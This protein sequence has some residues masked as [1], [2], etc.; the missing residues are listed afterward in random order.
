M[1]TFDLLA[2][3]GKHTKVFES[4]VNALLPQR[5][6][7]EISELLQ[8]SQWKI[9]KI[10]SGLHLET[11]QAR[12][13]QNIQSLQDMVLNTH[14]Y[15]DKENSHYNII[16]DEVSNLTLAVIESPNKE[17]LNQWYQELDR[18]TKGKIKG[19]SQSMNPHIKSIWKNISIIISKEIPKETREE[20][21]KTFIQNYS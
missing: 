9:Y 19:I 5:K 7:K 12:G 8:M 18:D 16:T 4:Q 11:V 21:S 17:S 3:N 6:V 13:T 10:I 1:E 15:I 20:Y 14:S 2:E